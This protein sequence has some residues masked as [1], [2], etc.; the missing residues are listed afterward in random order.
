MNYS[1]YFHHPKRILFRLLTLKPSWIS[2]EKYIKYTYYIHFGRFPDL[3]SPKRYTEK[4]QWF[5]LNV[6]DKTYSE[7]IDK[8]EVRKIVSSKI[9]NEHLIPLLG[10]WDDINEIDFDDLPLRFVLKCTHDSHSAIICDKTNAFSESIIR[11]N[12]S[13]SLRYNFYDNSRE[14]LYK[15]I[16]PRIIAEEYIYDSK[17]ETRDYK[18]W[19]FDGKV[20]F[21][22]VFCDRDSDLKMVTLNRDFS[23]AEFSNNNYSEYHQKLE[24]PKNYWEMVEIA[25]L[26]SKDF[27][28]VRIDL[29]NID[30]HIYFGEYTFTPASGFQH[31]E[32][33]KYDFIVGSY[34]NLF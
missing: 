22:N 34:W 7:Y 23:L 11:N 21:V 24:M 9:G 1:L 20:L 10:V 27:S 28:H 26:L 2:D 31:F 29:Y 15:N 18:F 6:R 13:N 33:D 17:G 25:E 8:Y 19:C 30:G 32:P 14:W 5:K 12:I 3:I 4:I 16:I